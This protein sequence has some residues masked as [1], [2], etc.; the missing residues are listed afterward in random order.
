MQ[1]GHDEAIASHFISIYGVANL[2]TRFAS[3]VFMFVFDVLF[4]EAL[5]RLQTHSSTSRQSNSSR[6]VWSSDFKVNLCSNLTLFC[7]HLQRQPSWSFVRANLARIPLRLRRLGYWTGPFIISCH[8]RAHR[9]FR[10]SATAQSHGRT[11][12]SHRSATVS[13]AANRW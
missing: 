5:D 2:L 6:C 4:L 10:R 13:Y 1:A 12:I 9:R 11:F 8:D 7:V 3:T